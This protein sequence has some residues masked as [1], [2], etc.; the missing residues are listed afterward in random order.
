MPKIRPPVNWYGGK[1]RMAG[2]IIEQFP[3][4]DIYL[5][6]FGGA[7]SVLLNKTP[8]PIEIYNDLNH[9]IVRLFRVL[10]ENP[11]ELL[12]KLKLMPY[13]Q[14]EFLRSVAW[15]NNKNGDSKLTNDV[16]AALFDYVRW[17]Q[18]FGGLGTHWSFTK[19]SKKGR[20]VPTW[21]FSVDQLPKVVERLRDVQICCEPALKFIKRFDHKD[22]L[23]YCDP[24]Y[25]HSTRCRRSRHAAYGD[26]EMSKKDHKELGE[27]LNNCE[28]QV[29]LSGYPSKLYD[30]LY[31]GWGLVEWDKGNGASPSST[32]RRM[33][34][35]LWSNF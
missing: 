35:C 2:K 27:V 1:G 9:S 14:E 10:R 24:P 16:D 17:R 31:A 19:A 28:S 34:E 20:A 4:H 15:H 12:S 29:L 26:L 22:A 6:P 30:R 21:K 8:S 18:S 11:E 33:K 32:Q 13:S 23:I 7:A 3:D 5:E 25:L